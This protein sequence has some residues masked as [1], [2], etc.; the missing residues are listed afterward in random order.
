MKLKSGFPLVELRGTTS[1]S[2]LTY[3]TINGAISARAKVDPKN[4]RSPEQ[5]LIRSYISTIGKNWKTLT[6]AQRTAWD[7]YANTFMSSSLKKH[8]SPGQNAYMITN[9]NR[10]ILGLTLTVNAPV[11]PPPAAL[12]ALGQLAAQDPDALGLE[13][14]HDIPVPAGHVLLVR[15][16]PATA[17][18]ARDPQV[19]DYRFV[20]GATVASTL[21]LPASGGS[22]VFRPTRYE[23]E[24]GARYGVE[25][26]VVRVADG[27]PSLS[28]FGDFIKSV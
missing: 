9:S 25:V 21:P 10:L 19:T 16:T 7:R 17:S 3:T 2:Q 4:P 28:S 1:N 14:F 6:N 13:V 15:M 11:E 26:R 23:I 12:K 18:A 8:V 27:V 24:D 5:Q 22:V 20:K